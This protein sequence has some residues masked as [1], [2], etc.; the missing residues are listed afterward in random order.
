M[1]SIRRIFLLAAVVLI[2]STQAIPQQPVTS[3]PQLADSGPTL[4]TTMKF[5]QE[6]LNSI[7]KITFDY[8]GVGDSSEERIQAMTTLPVVS[9]ALSDARADAT[10]CTLEVT[11]T[12]DT[13][14][15][16]GTGPGTVDDVDLGKYTLSFKDVA[17]IKIAPLSQRTNADPHFPVYVLILSAPAG[18]VTLHLTNTVTYYPDPKGK[19][20]R[21]ASTATTDTPGNSL[22]IDIVDEDLGNRLAKAMTHAIELCGGRS[23]DPF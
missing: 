23:K 5:I 8:P 18:T 16:P 12:R 2:D 19:H 21:P 7:G 1:E 15:Y 11:E 4:E 20:S 10:S 9:M 3:P 22:L 17:N 13:H 14:Y 6:K